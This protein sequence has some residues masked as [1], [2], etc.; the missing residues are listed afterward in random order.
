[1]NLMKYNLY[2]IFSLPLLVSC[3]Q[4]EDVAGELPQGT[5]AA[6]LKISGMP[7]VC[8]SDAEVDIKDL[9]GFRFEDGVLA[10]VFPSLALDKEGMCVFVP[11]REKG[12][13]YFLANAGAAEGLGKLKPGVSLLDDFMELEVSFPSL[14]LEVLPMTGSMAVEGKHTKAVLMKRSVARIDLSSFAKGVS[15]KSVVVRNVLTNGYM[16]ESEVV[17][18]P[19]TDEKTDFEKVFEDGCFMNRSEP[20]FYMAE[21]KNAGLAVE[22]LLDCNGSWQRLEARLPETIRRNTVYD[23]QVSGLGAS[24]KVDVI[25]GD[26]ESGD[27]TVSENRPLGVID[28]SASEL[29]GGVRINATNDTVHVPY[30]GSDFRL[31]LLGEEGARIKVEGTVDGVIVNQ[32]AA[33]TLQKVA[34]V[35]VS[36]K[37]R[38]PG[39]KKEYIYLDVYSRDTYA[40]RVVLVFEGSPVR[41]EGQ[42][43][44]DSDGICDFNRYIDGELGMITLPEGREIR[45]EFAGDSP[46]WMKLD[47]NEEGPWRLLGGWKP[48]DPEADGRVQEGKIVISGTDGLHR[49]VYTVRRI[50]WGLPVV[51]IHGTWWCKYNLR[52]NVKRFEDQVLI[53]SDPATQE[54]LAQYL[55][56]CSESELLALMGHQYQGGNND[57]LPLSHNGNSF[58]YD[59]MKSSGQN[60]GTMGP[61]EMAPDGYRIPSYEDYAFFSWGD[62]VNLGG[63]GSRPFNNK[64]GQRLNVTVAERD[65]SFLGNHFGVVSFYDFEQDG[66]HWVLYGLGHQWNTTP[67]SIARMNILFA[68]Y[69]HSSNTWGMEGYASS[70]NPGNNWFKFVPQNSQKTRTIRCVKNAVEYIYD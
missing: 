51:N 55:M 61:S 58:Y 66:N 67:G 8:G 63:V 23:L 31:V 1:M 59:G 21:Q 22:I 15:V 54:N 10:E 30:Y 34:E 29:S 62:N 26:W 69:G 24:A 47:Q 35:S 52:G 37:V 32:T 11:K 12:D 68:T 5:I 7:G 14:S 13:L 28:A 57:G 44:F 43:R 6:Q 4:K 50:N 41:L 27:G 33:R 56:N 18:M 45:L 42:I 53:Q 46:H 2:L 60:F 25:A 64:T 48:N 16:N 19:E 65:V 70:E 20:L 39:T 49:E 17:R 9:Q 36:S 38:M 40:A 3:S